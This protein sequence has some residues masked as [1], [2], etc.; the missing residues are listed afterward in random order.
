MD[1]DLEA[2]DEDVDASFDVDLP[3]NATLTLLVV[4]PSAFAAV[5]T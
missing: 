5:R 2:V 4:L 3:G 1:F